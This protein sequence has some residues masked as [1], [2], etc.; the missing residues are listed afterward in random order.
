MFEEE[1][2]EEAYLMELDDLRLRVP[3]GGDFVQV[4]VYTSGFWARAKEIRTEDL[5]RAIRRLS[6]FAKGGNRGHSAD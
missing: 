5:Q 1:L 2:D 3:V 6:R 4:E